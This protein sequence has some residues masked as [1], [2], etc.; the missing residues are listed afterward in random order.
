[1]AVVTGVSVHELA[2]NGLLCLGQRDWHATEAGRIQRVGT[3]VRPTPQSFLEPGVASM[4]ELVGKQSEHSLM[5]PRPPHAHAGWKATLG[6][7]WT[8]PPT[9][10]WD[11][12]GVV[13]HGRT[14]SSRGRRLCIFYQVEKRID[15]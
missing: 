5:V 14:L 9:V 8:C 1:M 6:A 12:I 15:H 13:G 10:N 4:K 11:G 3:S 2:T 7:L